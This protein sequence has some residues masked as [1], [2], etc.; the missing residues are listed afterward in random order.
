MKLTTQLNTNHNGTRC[1]IEELN[2]NMLDKILIEL[3]AMKFIMENSK[4]SLDS[5]LSH[6]T[7]KEQAT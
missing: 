6:Y 7:F 1:V 5:D 2:Y 4:A 3:V